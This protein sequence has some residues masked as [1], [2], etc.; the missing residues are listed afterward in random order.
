M[1]MKA[2]PECGAEISSEAKACPHC[3][4]TKK[5]PEHIGCGT[6]ILVGFL[7][8]VFV[9]LFSDDPDDSD[10]KDTEPK[11]AEERR[12]ERV[13]KAFSAWDGAHRNLER[14]I[15]ERLKDPDSYEH[16]ETRYVDQGE[17][18]VVYTKYRAKNSFGGY[19]IQEAGA[20]AKLD[21]TLISVNGNSVQ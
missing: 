5:E 18:V 17:H 20:K 14:Y 4:Y 21:G 8:L 11:T 12:Q 2:C 13:E 6:I 7:I 9:G 10:P 3:G 16:I 1:A 19:V 15:T